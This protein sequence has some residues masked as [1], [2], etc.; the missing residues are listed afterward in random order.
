MYYNGGHYFKVNGTA[1]VTK[2]APSYDIIYGKLRTVNSKMFS[3]YSLLMKCS[4][5]R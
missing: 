1:M 2:T 5:L 4:T 3:Y